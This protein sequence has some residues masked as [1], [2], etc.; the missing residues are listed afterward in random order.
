MAGK[1]QALITNPPLRR[2][3][4]RFA[5][6]FDIPPQAGLILKSFLTKPHFTKNLM[7]PTE[8]KTMAMI[9]KITLVVKASLRPY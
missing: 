7:P 2:M 1:K 8:R 5:S 9:L 3:I 4:Y 6:A